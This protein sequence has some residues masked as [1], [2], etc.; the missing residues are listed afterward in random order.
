MLLQNRKIFITT[1]IRALGLSSDEDIRDFFG[2]DP[3]IE[4]TLE[5]DETKKE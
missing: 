3:R 5:K 2:Y 4:A 1:F